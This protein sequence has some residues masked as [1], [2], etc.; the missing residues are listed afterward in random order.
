MTDEQRAKECSRAIHAAGCVLNSDAE[1]YIESAI[2]AAVLDERRRIA[3]TLGQ[4]VDD[5]E[6]EI[7]GT[8]ING[9]FVAGRISMREAVRRE[10]EECAKMAEWVDM[11]EDLAERIR[12]RSV[13]V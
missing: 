12:A 10:R 5:P 6:M 9:G 4:M 1:D 3:L 7:I 11:A 13:E 2:R 8:V